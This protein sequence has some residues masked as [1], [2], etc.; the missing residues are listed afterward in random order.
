MAATREAVMNALLAKVATVAQFAHVSR[1]ID[2]VPGAPTPTVATPPAQPALYLFEDHESTANRGRGI[3]PV[4]HWYVELWVWAKNPTG[5]TPGVPDGI[6]PGMSIINPL[7]EAIEGAFSRDNFITNEF[8][9]GGL[10]QYCQIAGT[11]VKI[12]GDA[13]P[14]GQCLAMIPVKIMV[15]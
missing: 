1:H 14:E 11:T 2:L 8:T 12:S 5:A 10:V 9:L 6:T 7:I 15:P 3:P 4:R 13:N